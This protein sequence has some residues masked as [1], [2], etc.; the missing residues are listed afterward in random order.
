M[1]EELKRLLLQA[2]AN[3]Q[4]AFAALLSRYSPMIESLLRRIRSAQMSEEDI[5]D[6]RQ[7]AYVCFYR[8]LTRYDMEQ[9][10]VDFGLYAKICVDRGLISATRAMKHLSAAPTL[11]LDELEEFE[12]T[13]PYVDPSAQLVEE[14][15]FRHL[16]AQVCRLLS[17]Y[18]NEVWRLYMAGHSAATIARRTGR[19]EKSIHNAI[20]RIRQ[21]LRNALSSQS[22]D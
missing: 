22:E 3:D 5:K 13:E 18:E 11:P 6:L 12:D 19:E 2:R 1:T 4:S 10:E 14:E 15:S 21:K 9:S 20:Y 8:A 16:Y 7:E 17:P